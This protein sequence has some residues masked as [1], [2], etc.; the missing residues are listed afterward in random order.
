MWLLQFVPDWTFYALGCIALVALI[1]SYFLKH[2]PFISQYA[3]PIWII[4]LVL[5][6]FAIYMSGALAENRR[7]EAKIAIKEKEWMAAQPKI[8]K[9]AAEVVIKYVTKREV[10][11]EKARVE[12]EVIE[13]VITQYDN[14]CKIVPEMTALL[15]A[16]AKGPAE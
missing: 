2:I 5:L 9:A 11:R 6:A 14:T 10:I 3:L 1:G 12:T 7:W 8:E 13:K 4:S 16:S 15:N